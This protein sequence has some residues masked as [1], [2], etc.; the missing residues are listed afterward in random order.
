MPRPPRPL[1]AD[2]LRA[3]KLTR[4]PGVRIAEAC[5]R[6]GVAKTAVSRARKENDPATQ[7]SANEL[8]GLAGIAGWIDYVNK[9]G[10]TAQDVLRMLGTFVTS[11]Q[12]AIEGDRWT[13]LK[14][15][16]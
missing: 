9:D 2:V 6:F 16:P 7:V 11:G 13:L 10:S 1:S 14:P 3:A 4:I 5:E 12:L 8:A 15:W